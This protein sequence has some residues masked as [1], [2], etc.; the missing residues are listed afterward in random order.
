MQLRPYQQDV[1]DRVN[2]QW[3]SGKRDVLAVMPTGAG[4]TALFSSI[5]AD[6]PGACAAIAHRQELVSQMSL[7]LARNGVRH[8]VIGGASTQRL[9]ATMQME[10]FGHVFVDP[11]ARCGV[12]GIDTLIRMQPTDPWLAQVRLA[13]TDEAHHVLTENKWGK[14]LLMFPNAR[15]LGVTA[16]PTRADG[17][18]LGRHADGVFDSMVV[19]PGMRDLI[20]AG[21]LTDY[22]VFCPESDINLARVGVTSGGEFNMDQLRDAVHKSHIVGDIVGSYIKYAAGKLGITFAVDIETAQQITDAYRLAGVSAELVT[23]K[24]P[25]SVRTNIMRRFRARQIQQLVNVDLFGEGFDVPAVEVVSMGRPTMSYSL[26]SQQFGRA[27]RPLAGKDRAIII[28]HVSN[29]VR[30]HGPPDVPKVW[31]LN[32]RERAPKGAPSDV[33]PIRV[34]ANESCVQPYERA[35][36]CCPYCGTYPEPAGRS[37]PAQVDGD[38]TE[39]DESVLR[40]MRGEIAKVDGLPHPP[41]N[42]G[43]IV[44]SS[45][46]KNHKARQDAQGSLRHAISLYGGWQVSQGR[47]VREA[48]KRFYLRY[49]V[50]VMTAQA[51][52]K[53]DAAELEAKIRAELAENGIIDASVNYVQPEQ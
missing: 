33:V 6:E 18:G 20:T 13:V 52:G 44:V 48:Q 11:N 9:C 19:G 24:T 7:T 32:R 1:K 21:Y 22:R 42:A 37:L 14:G 4:K 40:A 29:L 53:T 49:G 2:E 31:T 3:S 5:L 36:V 17:K 51:L 38:L 27:L 35:L 45:I 23:G 41:M 25:D 12:A 50:D 34:C 47:S 28:D 30:H 43:P 15:G 10:E 26:Y 39:L 8:R 16:T 46:M